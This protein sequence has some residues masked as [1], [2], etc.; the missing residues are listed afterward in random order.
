VDRAAPPLA[1]CLESYF[2]VQGEIPPASPS[3]TASGS[4]LD[5][6]SPVNITV[7]GQDL[8]VLLRPAYASFGPDPP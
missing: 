8:T 4:L 1:A 6:L 3:A 5:Q 2:A 7:R